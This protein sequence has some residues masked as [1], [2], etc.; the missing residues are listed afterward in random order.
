MSEL[1]ILKRLSSLCKKYKNTRGYL[2]FK[3]CHPEIDLIFH[4]SGDE[5]FELFFRK[6]I[7]D[8]NS[9]DKEH[10]LIEWFEPS[11]NLNGNNPKEISLDE[12]EQFSSL[13]DIEILLIHG[14]GLS[15]ISI[16]NF[17]NDQLDEDISI[18]DFDN[19]IKNNPVELKLDGSLKIGENEYLKFLG[20]DDE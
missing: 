15:D 9:E 11:F 12:L 18:L 20:L 10:I 16:I 1:M 14:R 6:D 5:Y 3:T 2:G 7:L 4:S 19:F 17:I 13:S 8:I